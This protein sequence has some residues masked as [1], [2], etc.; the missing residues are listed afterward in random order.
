[1][2]PYVC[3]ATMPLFCKPNWPRRLATFVKRTY[4]RSF[5]K[6]N[7]QEI[8]NCK[9][10]AIERAKESHDE[11][12]SRTGNGSSIDDGLEEGTDSI[13]ST[14]TCKSVKGVGSKSTRVTK[15]QKFVV[16]LL[17]FHVFLQFFL[18]YSHFITQVH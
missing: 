7:R 10:I 18:P 5:S 13:N 3:L 1:M 11:I 17:L 8:R 4:A 9:R 6:R 14:I 16:S 12:N 15:K 2:F